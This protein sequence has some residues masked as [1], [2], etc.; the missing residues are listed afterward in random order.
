VIV[1]ARKA[2]KQGKALEFDG[3]ERALRNARANLYSGR[4]VEPGEAIHISYKD[5]V[6]QIWMTFDDEMDGSA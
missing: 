1:A 3:D 4:H 2:A 6:I 5:G